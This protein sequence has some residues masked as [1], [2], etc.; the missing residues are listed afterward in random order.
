V[1]GAAVGEY[2]RDALAAMLGETTP[3]AVVAVPPRAATVRAGLPN[4]TDVPVL[5]PDRRVGPGVVDR[6]DVL[7]VT[8]P[9]SGSGRDPS[10]PGRPSA[11]DGRAGTGRPAGAE[12]ETDDGDR[13]TDR[14]HR[15]CL[16]ACVSLD[17]DPYD[18]S[19]SF[20]GLRA[21]AEGLPDGW[22]TADATHC[23]TELRA[24][25]RT[26]VGVD[27]GRCSLVG[28]GR[29]GADLG[30][31]TDAGVPDATLVAVYP[32]GAVRTGTVDPESFG[33]QGLDGVGAKRADTLRRAGYATPGDV[34]EAPPRD[35]ASLQGFGSSTAASIRAAATARVRGTV[36]ATGDDPLPRGDPVFVDI[37]TDG[38]EPSVAW[39]VGVLDGSARDGHYLA[40]RE[41]RPGDGSHLEAFLSWLR[42]EAGDRPLVAW[43]G[44][45]F[46]FP[47]L[48]D[49]IREQCPEHL[50]AWEAASK[51]DP[52]RWARRTGDG[53]AALPGHNDELGTVASALGWEP[54]TT[55]IDGG[56]VA[57]LYTAYR[58]AWLA[59]ADP[60]NVPE[61]DWGR[62]EA[63]CEDDVRALA[64]VY[65]A[66]SDAARRESQTGPGPGPDP[67]DG[68]R[69]G[70]L[71]EF[72]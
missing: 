24:G 36:V 47:V 49:R 64:T 53:N 21:Y 28:V 37:E 32:N 59:A 31:G 23:S 19:T 27:G 22:L 43:N 70:A 6:G 44:Y 2:H 4:D 71:S 46:D 18:R 30:V 14:T 1:S 41:P 33:L 51:F 48:R 16:T 17:V 20:D 52:L 7:V 61:P 66:L 39:L 40:F 38:L 63:Y 60:R 34:V 62:L 58:R 57:E 45:G 35:L 9:D 68:S 55:G 29:S 25:F 42:A 13:T 15:V 54:A 3:T 8:V 11:G 10:D 5:S 67:G 26:T 69:Q 12:L 65:G 72:T 56:V 50:D